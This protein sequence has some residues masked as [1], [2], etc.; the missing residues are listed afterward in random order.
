MCSM[1]IAIQRPEIDAWRSR[2]ESDRSMSVR[3]IAELTGVNRGVINR[4]MKQNGWSRDPKT[5][6]DSIAAN[7]LR[8]KEHKADKRRGKRASAP[9]VPRKIERESKPRGRNEYPHIEVYRA[10]YATDPTLT[11]AMI[12]E[13]CGEKHAMVE[14]YARRM[15]WERPDHIKRE[16]LKICAL[17]KAEER[18][19]ARAEAKISAYPKQTGRPAAAASIFG[20]GSGILVTTSRHA[21][22]PTHMA[23]RIDFGA[24]K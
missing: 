12:A 21:S 16:Q 13:K 17:R 10:R 8:R 19:R 20:Y 1:T 2:W 6:A 4:H 15:L 18:A 7:A 3:I 23:V 11:L 9:H 22:E 5:I 24:S 14:A